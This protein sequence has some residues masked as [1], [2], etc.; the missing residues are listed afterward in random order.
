VGGELGRRTALV[1][2][3]ALALTACG[4]RARV[5]AAGSTEKKI[6]YAEDHRDQYGVLGLPSGTPRGTIVLLH[7]GFWL[8]Q[9]GAD[10]MEP[11]ATDLRQRGWATWN[12]E[13]RRV[14]SG[15]GYPRTFLDVAT[16]IDRV[17]LLGIGGSGPVV[18]LGHS[19]GGHLAVWA[20][21]RTPATP[22]AAPRV[23]PGRTLSLSG[24]L[25]L[26]TA[27]TDDLDSG[28]VSGLMGTD[29]GSGSA[30]Y[31]VADPTRL[32]PAHG[33]VAAIHA[34]QD[35]IV[36]VTQSRNYVAADTRAG[37]AA[38]LV[39]VPGGHFDLIDPASA[40]WSRIVQQL[41]GR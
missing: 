17:P 19:A 34:E 39:L 4:A 6:F 22:G 16:A 32:V 28:A 36:P 5:R 23:R 12:V 1:G 2:A 14:G 25:D 21:S 38:Q 31:A 24:V 40:A 8:D 35:E 10:L 18:T 41:P 26:T 29:P 7:G 37:G 30:A 27:Y 11:I 20:A 33:P 3:A 15:G 9:Y 13:Y